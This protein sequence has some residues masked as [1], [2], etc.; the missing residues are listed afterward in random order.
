[1]DDIM[2]SGHLSGLAQLAQ[3]RSFTGAKGVQLIRLFDCLEDVQV[4]IK[5]R[6]GRY[7]WVN[8]AFLTNYAVNE[9][10]PYA[11][12]GGVQG[13]TDHEL[14]SVCL[15]DQY[16]ADDKQ[17][18]AG[19]AVVNRIELVGQPDGG[20]AWSVTN[21]IPL[22]ASN[23]AVIG[24]AG[25]TW[26]LREEDAAMSPGTRFGAVLNH[27]RDHYREPITNTQLARLAGLSVRAF[28]RKFL[29]A[30]RVPPQRYLRKLRL[31]MAS[32]ALVFSHRSIVEVA[33]DCG[34]ADQSHF[35]REFRRH[36]GRTPRDYRAWYARLSAAPIT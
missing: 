18:L 29:A 5:D 19:Q 28:E 17:V 1:M 12:L 16:E 21:K 8:R 27:V 23:G 24:T 13:K 30:F 10:V 26:R 11:E 14:C 25:L 20:A 36:F 2:R 31:R 7:V 4:W 32:H 9:E 34:F 35:T 33:L 22:Q 6:Q 3:L 15:A